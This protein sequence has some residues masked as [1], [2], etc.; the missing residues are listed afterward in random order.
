MK[1]IIV[2]LIFLFVIFKI[3]IWLSNEIKPNYW[4][5]FY[6]PN[7][8][9]TVDIASPLFSTKAQCLEW[10]M[11][12]KNSRNNLNDDFECGLNCIRKQGR[13]VSVCE[14]TTDN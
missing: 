5:G 10:A 1:N 12:L 4:Q 3:L 13:L 14:E 7:G 11:N 8:N 9:T 6:Y 2:I